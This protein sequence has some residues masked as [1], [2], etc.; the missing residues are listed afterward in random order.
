MLVL[1]QRFWR[2]GW[3][4]HPPQ[5]LTLHIPHLPKAPH[6][7]TAS[8]CG[9]ASTPGRWHS[10]GWTRPEAGP[11]T[12]QKI[13]WASNLPG[14][15]PVFRTLDSKR[16]LKLHLLPHPRPGR[17][18]WGWH[19]HPSWWPRSCRGSESS[20][21]RRS[22]LCWAA[23]SCFC[24]WCWQKIERRAPRHSWPGRWGRP[25][26]QRCLLGEKGKI[27]CAGEGGGLLRKMLGSGFMGKILPP[28]VE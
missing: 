25:H 13:L 12:G 14:A 4:P 6:S 23:E 26:T 7:L 28:N 15:W 21:C 11:E 3:P 20:G 16:S 27:V 9:L 8:V 18:Q 22:R 17:E 2:P 19:T 10:L 1:V 5:A 24:W